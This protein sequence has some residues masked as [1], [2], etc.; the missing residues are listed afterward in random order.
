MV[1]V[2]E[3]IVLRLFGLA[4]AP[5]QGRVWT[6]SNYRKKKCVYET[7]MDAETYLS[8]MVSLVSQA[9]GTQKKED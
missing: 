8:E 1:C 9:I 3:T 7:I 2:Y 4:F 6:L 5:L